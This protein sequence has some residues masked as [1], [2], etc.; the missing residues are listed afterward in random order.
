MR[1]LVLILCLI[2]NISFSQP[3]P[4]KHEFRG[5]WITSAYNLDWPS[6]F[7]ITPEQQRQE[8]LAILDRHQ[9]NGLNTIIV[10]VRAAADAYYQSDIE[11]WSYW[12][13]GKQGKAPEPFW[14]PLQFMI[15]ECHKRNM[16]IHA[17][18]N[19]FRAISHDRFFK[20]CKN[21]PVSK[22]S[23]WLYKI[24]T[25][26]FFDPGIPEVREYLTSVIT[27]CVEKY[28]I[29]GV[30]LDDYFYAQESKKEKVNDN[31]TFKKH[32][33][34]FTDLGD[35]RRNNINQ[36]IK[37]LSDSIHHT[38]PYVKF[39]I[40][41]VP[42]WRHKS[43]DENGSETNRTLTCYDDLFA[44]SRL[45]IKNGWIDYLAPQ[46]YWSTKHKRVN[47]NKLLEW[48]S[49]NTFDHHIYIGL[50]YYKLSE[51]DDK[52]WEDPH[53]ILDQIELIRNQKNIKGFSFF[54]S[55]SFNGNPLHMEDSL[56]KK[57]NSYFCLP[58]T[59][60]WLDSIPPLAPINL[61]GERTP[62]SIIL[63]WKSP[64][65]TTKED[66]PYRY[67]IYRIRKGEMFD[68]NTSKNIIAFTAD[69]SFV[70][71]TVDN[72]FEYTYFISSTD[73]LHNESTSFSGI[74][75]GIKH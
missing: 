73:R 72:Q 56:R 45:W 65:G 35:W 3:P 41:P 16:E 5:V 7:E 20:L 46:L 64:R 6:S 50:A 8:F 40:S 52:G 18:F 14:D 57:T 22:H 62:N 37:M 25:K 31:K 70:D 28:D 36:L 67:I 34:D 49:N 21:H 53:Q 69:S 26:S 27:N 71:K 60:P 30:H 4:I 61:T 75:I 43:D 38:K 17:W 68:V 2:A 11:P 39:G 54:R 24:G 51:P 32:K 63:N 44:D 29:D 9:K 74:T 13:T 33:G 59:M 12:L 19:L 47:Y 58:P 1:K 42:V 15:D 48:Y 55:S 10:Q 23:D 66:S